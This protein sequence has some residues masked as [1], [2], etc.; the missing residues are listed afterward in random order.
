MYTQRLENLQKMAPAAES[1]IHS[2]Y[3]A[4][5][6][7]AYKRNTAKVQ[8]IVNCLLNYLTRVYT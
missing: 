7:M 3:N 4:R 1:S 6:S 8:I 5:S 2:F